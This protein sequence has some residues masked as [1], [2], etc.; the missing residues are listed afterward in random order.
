MTQFSQMAQCMCGM[1]LCVWERARSN[2]Y[3]TSARQSISSWL[4]AFAFRSFSLSLLFPPPPPCRFFLVRLFVDWFFFVFVNA[5]KFG[6]RWNRR[7]VRQTLNEFEA[8]DRSNGSSKQRNSIW[9]SQEA[10]MS[11]LSV[12]QINKCCCCMRQTV[13]GHRRRR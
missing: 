7:R 13:H 2:G 8:K 11:R 9:G 12:N 3:C 4:F 5:A 10:A 6:G 1:C